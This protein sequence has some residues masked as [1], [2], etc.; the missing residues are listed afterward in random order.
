MSEA[1]M[2][3]LTIDAMFP[4]R[5]AACEEA[6]REARGALFSLQHHDPGVAGTLG[7]LRWTRQWRTGLR[8][9]YWEDPRQGAT[10]HRFAAAGPEDAR[11]LAAIAEELQRR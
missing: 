3:E 2:D 4:G 6:V 9:E 10:F 11:L 5:L 7:I 8:Q 1:T